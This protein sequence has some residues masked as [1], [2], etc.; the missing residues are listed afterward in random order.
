MSRSRIFPG[1]HRM[2]KKERETGK[3]NKAFLYGVAV[4][5]IASFVI[6]AFR[7]RRAYTQ[8][9]LA[10]GLEKR[11]TQRLSLIG[12]KIESLRQDYLNTPGSNSIE[13]ERLMGLLDQAEVERMSITCSLSLSVN[14]RLM[15]EA[16]EERLAV[17]ESDLPE[18]EIY[19]LDLE[20][21]TGNDH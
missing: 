6:S 4:I 14:E 2:S 3:L 17:M 12:Q 18:D 5:G 21:S 16:A 13:R 8:N 9:E 20:E 11:T 10:L 15:I 7:Q 1:V 19:Y